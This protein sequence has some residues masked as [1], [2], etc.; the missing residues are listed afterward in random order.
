M[1]LVA[2]EKKTKPTHSKFFDLKIKL[3]LM[4]ANGHNG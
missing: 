4:G 3:E 1:T 2:R